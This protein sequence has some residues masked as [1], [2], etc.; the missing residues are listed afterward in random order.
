M[1]KVIGIFLTMVLVFLVL[2]MNVSLAENKIV[3]GYCGSEVQGFVE[4]WMR[5]QKIDEKYYDNT[6]DEFG[7]F[8]GHGVMLVDEFEESFGV[9]WNDESMYKV[10]SEH[11]NNLEFEV[12]T[13]G[14]YEG[15]NVYLMKAKSTDAI[16]YYYSYGEQYP[17]Y[18]GE[19]IYMACIEP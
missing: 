13:I 11:Y 7:Y 17:Y 1:K 8:Y 19:M 10:L 2:S 14:F 15:F 12:K 4:E 3:K 5:S 6:A 16:G 9:E 18:E